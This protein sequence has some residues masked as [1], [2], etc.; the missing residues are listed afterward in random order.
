[1]FALISSDVFKYQLIKTINKLK[2]EGWQPENLKLI[3]SEQYETD[4][5]FFRFAA[6]D[7]FIR[8]K[9]DR[10]IE[11]ALRSNKGVELLKDYLK[12]EKKVNKPED[13]ITFVVSMFSSTSSFN[14]L[15]S[16]Q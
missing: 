12:Y 8:N 5:I 16:H 4:D 9:N 2:K 3:I 10:Y 11:M 7:D 1:M 15:L 6:D 14:F 13:W